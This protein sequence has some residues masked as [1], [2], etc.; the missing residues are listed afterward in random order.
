M[1]I[2]VSNMS[3]NAFFTIFIRIT[4]PK[5]Y[6]YTAAVSRIA[7]FKKRLIHVQMIS[8]SLTAICFSSVFSESCNLHPKIIF[9]CIKPTTT[10]N[11]TN[12][13][14]IEKMGKKA[15]ER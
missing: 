13:E 4:S 2:N 9:Y 15:Q 1:I 5:Y 11:A 6:W 3:G 7:G 12:Y 14:V 8:A 10:K